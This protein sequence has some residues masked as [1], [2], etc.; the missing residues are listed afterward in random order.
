MIPSRYREQPANKGAEGI[1]LRDSTTMSGS[2]KG[3]IGCN[4]FVPFP[5]YI[6]IVHISSDHKRAHHRHKIVY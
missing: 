5:H 6:H 2:I 4:W 3:R 1:Q